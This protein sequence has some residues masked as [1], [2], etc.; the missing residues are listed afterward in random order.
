MEI[1]NASRFALRLISLSKVKYL[2]RRRK[3]RGRRVIPCY[4]SEGVKDD[5]A[6]KFCMEGLDNI[7]MNLCK[8][9]SAMKE[10]DQRTPVVTFVSI[11]EKVRIILRF[12]WKK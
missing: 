5:D 10:S 7:G 3:S 8:M 2:S 12:H 11:G 6:V 1:R 9:S 4:T